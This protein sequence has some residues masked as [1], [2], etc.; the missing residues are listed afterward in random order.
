MLATN[1]FPK[2]L[3]VK[4]SDYPDKIYT[5]EIKYIPQG[6]GLRKMFPEKSEEELMYALIS[7]FLECTRL[8]IFPVKWWN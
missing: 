8:R 7:Y 4:M 5:L 3:V 1:K 2:F 6:A